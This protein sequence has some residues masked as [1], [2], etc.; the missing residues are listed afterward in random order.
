MRYL[1]LIL[2]IFPFLLHAQTVPAGRDS[3]LWKPA[4]ADSAMKLLRLEENRVQ[5]GLLRSETLSFSPKKQ[6]IV[7]RY[8]PYMATDNLPVMK[9]I[10]KVSKKRGTVRL[11]RVLMR[12]VPIGGDEMSVTGKTRRLNGEVLFARLETHKG[13]STI[14]YIKIGAFEVTYKGKVTLVSM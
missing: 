6:V 8:L 11:T 1:I 4:N 10:T 14:S 2:L 12:P 9:E 5:S 3:V 7:Y 13:N